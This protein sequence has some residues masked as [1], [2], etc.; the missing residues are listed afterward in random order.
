[1]C[2]LFSS[3]TGETYFQLTLT[4][5]DPEIWAALILRP[6]TDCADSWRLKL[7]HRPSLRPSPRILKGPEG[8]KQLVPPEPCG[9]LFQR[10]TTTEPFLIIP[11]CLR[12]TDSQ[13]C[14][15]PR[16]RGKDLTLVASR[17][18]QGPSLVGQD[19]GPVK[20]KV[21]Q[22]CGLQYVLKE[23]NYRKKRETFPIN[24]LHISAYREAFRANPNP[25]PLALSL[26]LKCPWLE[27]NRTV[28]LTCR[29]QFNVIITN[30]FS[31]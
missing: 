24:Q 18:P 10:I 3:L 21:W 25:F 30:T 17:P 28:P 12:R 7:S 16:G 20:L 14:N 4:V 9:L 29:M 26:L 2:L 13:A 31:E 22:E 15:E 8:S 11:P 23:F 1:M 27:I 19:Q 6:S 5:N